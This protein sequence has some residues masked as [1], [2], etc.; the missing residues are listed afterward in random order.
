MINKVYFRTDV[1]T[2][3][4]LGNSQH[5]YGE[6]SFT[7]GEPMGKNKQVTSIEFGAHM[8]VPFIEVWV[9]SQVFCEI[10][11]TSVARIYYSLEDDTVS[12]GDE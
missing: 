10:P 8:S 4:L 5:W 12:N 1:D 6:D 3:D 7:L 11:M 9:N 2:T